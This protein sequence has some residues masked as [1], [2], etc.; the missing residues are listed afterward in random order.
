MPCE[1]IVAT[2]NMLSHDI[3]G[4]LSLR[5]RFYCC[6]TPL[7]S[8]INIMHRMCVCAHIDMC[9]HT[10][11]FALLML[12][13]FGSF[14]AQSHVQTSRISTHTLSQAVWGVRVYEDLGLEFEPFQNSLGQ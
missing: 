14:G 5:R 1:V 4:F 12:S 9:M 7:G 10:T 8:E 3:P 13:C 6:S 11:G 2:F